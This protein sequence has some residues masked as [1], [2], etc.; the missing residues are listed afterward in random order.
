MAVQAQAAPRVALVAGSSG[1]TGAALVRLLLRQG[2]HAR[3]HAL[4]RRPLPL[5]N[6]RLANR[7]L[8]LEE[9]GPRLMGLR[10][11]DAFCCLGAAGGPRASAAALR[12][13]DLQL[14]LG[15]ATAALAAGATRLV[16]VSAAGADSAAAREFLR[17]KG[18]LEA[19]LRALKFAAVDVLQPAVVVGLRADSPWQE[20]LR[21]GLLPFLGPLQRGP[22][23]ARRWISGEDL[24]AAMLGAAR[25]QRRGFNYYG[26]ERLLQL[27]AAGRQRS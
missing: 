21:I 24:A 11:T 18:E 6:T 2:D 9:I 22:L 14:V 19:A 16:V 20:T 27:T 25:S 15:F 17:V 1:L 23:A 3:V 8:P 12:H 13:T 10:C 5:D 7:V 4:S 26:G